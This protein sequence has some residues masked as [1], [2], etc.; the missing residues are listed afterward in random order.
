MSLVLL[1]IFIFLAHRTEVSI[2]II[3][4]GF[5]FR[6]PPSTKKKTEI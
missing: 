2:I 3:N 1:I 5:Y 6:R 4:F